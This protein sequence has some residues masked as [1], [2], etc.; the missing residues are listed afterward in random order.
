M[1]IEGLSQVIRLPRLNKIRMGIKV[2][3][4]NGKEHPQ[5]TEYFVCPPEVQKVYGEK[6]TCLDV[7]IP[8]EDEELWASTWYR[9]Y[10][11]TQ[12]LVCW[13][14]GRGPNNY[15]CERLYDI[16]TGERAH[17]EAKH[18]EWRDY[19]CEDE[20]CPDFKA[21]NGCKPVMQ[22]RF[23]L[24]KVPGLGIYE[25]DTSSRNSIINVQS[26]AKYIRDIYK[27]RIAGIP[28][29]LTIGPKSVNLPDSAKRQT[30]YVLNFNTDLTLL[31]MA[32]ATKKF[33]ELMPAGKRF[34]IAPPSP[35][36]VTPE[37][38]AVD[39]QEPPSNP[40][41]TKGQICPPASGPN[42]TACSTSQPPDDIIFPDDKQQEK[43]VKGTVKPQPV[44]PAYDF[45]PVWLTDLLKRIKWTDKTTKS[46]L[47][48]YKVDMKGTVVEI[49]ARLKVEDR[50]LFFQELADREVMTE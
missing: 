26:C 19:T 35:E 30:V 13:G 39:G 48:R 28:L 41:T 46:Y 23:C 43:T 40:E 37:D 7:A 25:I 5:K 8:V 1:P 18:T 9:L 17:K 6:T 34:E 10:S 36:D 16:E 22:L 45:E 47:E 4:A 21:E 38:L 31:E 42:S 3:G 29:K 14:G 49:T 2:V 33:Q 50:K 11:A 12:G 44:Q 24:Y 20:D 32:S 15:P 27:G